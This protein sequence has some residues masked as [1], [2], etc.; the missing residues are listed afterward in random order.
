MKLNVIKFKSVK[1]TNDEAIK[2]IKSKN[3]YSGIVVSEKQIKGKGTMGKKWVSETGNLFI[4]IFFQVD[5]EK[6][7]IKDF[8][9][10]N[11]NSIKKIL[12][13]YSRKPITIKFPN[14]LLIDGRK[15]CGILQEIIVY[16][17]DKYLIT[18]IGI[19]SIKAT[20]NTKFKATS[21][22]NN[23]DKKIYNHFILKDIIKYYEEVIIDLKTS[24]L[25][26]I[27]N[28]YIN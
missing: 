6:F 18:G 5:L 21:L 15:L 28:K 7:K 13:E 4:S 12:T 25:N 19:N 24:N 17:D 20:V 16:K 3:I 9:L 22:K 27:K 2:L 23:S 14:D 8:L 11:V 1:S 10:L 26:F